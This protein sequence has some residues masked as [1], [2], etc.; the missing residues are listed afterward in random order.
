MVAWNS[1]ACTSW[2]VRQAAGCDTDQQLLQHLYVLGIPPLLFLAEPNVMS[3]EDLH[4]QRAPDG[5]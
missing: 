5:M 4:L 3:P 1:L 2:A